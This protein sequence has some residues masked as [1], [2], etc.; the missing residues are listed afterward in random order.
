MASW[1]SAKSVFH[2]AMWGARK[3]AT[4]VRAQWMTAGCPAAPPNRYVVT[5]D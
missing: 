3:W 1:I 2:T 5:K 4:L